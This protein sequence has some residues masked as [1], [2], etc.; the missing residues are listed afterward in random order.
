MEAEQ[1]PS[2]VEKP[3]IINETETERECPLNQRRASQGRRLGVAC[4]CLEV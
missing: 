3:V 2:L 1:L 4:W